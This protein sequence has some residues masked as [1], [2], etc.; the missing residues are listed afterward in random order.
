MNAGITMKRILII[1][2]ALM[3]L[4][5]LGACTGE[6]P[7]SAGSSVSSEESSDMHMQSSERSADDAASE[8]V[9]VPEESKPEGVM[10]VQP[11]DGADAELCLY[12]DGTFT[13]KVV[14][15]DGIPEL[16]GTYED[17][18]EAYIL[19]V[20]ESNSMALDIATLGDMRFEKSGDM[21][22]YSGTEIGISV[23]GAEFTRR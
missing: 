10:Y 12:E 20:V 19:T 16:K 4:G 21:L 23:E 2:C 15:Y 22:I 14:M 3:I 11:G 13:F 6:V 8:G 18:G 1:L 17:N 7:S 5:S 9:S